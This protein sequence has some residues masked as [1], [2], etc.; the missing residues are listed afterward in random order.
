[1]SEHLETNQA[2]WDEKVSFHAE[3]GFYDVEAFKA[4]KLTFQP[5]CRSS[6][7]TSSPPPAIACSRS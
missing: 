2:W 7:S 5:A 6:S 4:G 3:S 1:M